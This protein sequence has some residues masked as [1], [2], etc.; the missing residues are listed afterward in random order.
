MSTI[1]K[2]GRGEI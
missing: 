1:Q 2:E